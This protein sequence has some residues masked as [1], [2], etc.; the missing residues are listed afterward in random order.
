VLVAL[1]AHR[2]FLVSLFLILPHNK[3]DARSV[4]QVIYDTLESR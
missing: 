4:S 1:S 3:F 2:C